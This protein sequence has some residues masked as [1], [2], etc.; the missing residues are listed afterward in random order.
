MRRIRKLMNIISCLEA[1]AVHTLSDQRSNLLISSKRT[2]SNLVVHIQAKFILE[3]L[4]GTSGSND[5]AM[6]EEVNILF[7]K[8]SHLGLHLVVSYQG[9]KSSAGVKEEERVAEVC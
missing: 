5:A 9:Y 8:T 3:G 4:A 6:L 7:N 2:G 1:F